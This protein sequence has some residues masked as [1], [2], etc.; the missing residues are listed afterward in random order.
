MLNYL[1]IFITQDGKMPK[2]S[3]FCQ[4]DEKGANLACTLPWFY[5]IKCA[6][7]R[8]QPLIRRI[9]SISQLQPDSRGATWLILP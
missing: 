9:S 7:T 4:G 8:F 5:R 1:A 3:M 6:P 2:A